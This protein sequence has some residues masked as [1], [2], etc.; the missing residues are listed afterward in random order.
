MK[1]LQTLPNRFV[2]RKLIDIYFHI[3]RI[4]GK[5]LPPDTGIDIKVLEQ[6]VANKEL[7]INFN[8]SVEIIMS[9]GNRLAQLKETLPHLI[10]C[11]NK[12]A[13][14]T[15]SVFADCENTSSWISESFE[16]E[17]RTGLL[18]VIET[19]S[20]SFNK[21]NALNVA[22]LNSHADYVFLIDSDILIKNKN[23]LKLC[24][25]HF[26][27]NEFSL[28]SYR[29]WGQ[30]YLLRSDY[31][32]INGYASEIQD[33][34]GHFTSG[35]YGDDMDFI[36]RTVANLGN[37]LFISK[38]QDYVFKSRFKKRIP[39]FSH[40]LRKSEFD[41]FEHIDEKTIIDRDPQDYEKAL[42]FQRI[43]GYTSRKDQ[44]L[45]Q[46]FFWYRSKKAEKSR[47]QI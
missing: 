6:I 3:N 11:L 20:I 17:I 18:K 7:E 28:V 38:N 23:F 31:L 34:D 37:F 21:A 14:L 2:Y 44:A 1:L 36:V 15:I 5:F 12:Q 4:R 27:L 40:K 10:P 19:K 26:L 42:Y 22:V 35:V 47:G 8:S 24:Y 46:Y 30:Q 45:I 13:T 33:H 16:H 29:Y 39:I 43:G 32:K 25:M 41:F 9:S